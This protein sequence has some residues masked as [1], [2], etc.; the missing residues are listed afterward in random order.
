MRCMLCVEFCWI[1]PSKRNS[2]YSRQPLYKGVLAR[3]V[4][5]RTDTH[6]GGMQGMA[7]IVMRFVALDGL[8]AENRITMR[9]SLLL[10]NM[11]RCPKTFFTGT[12]ALYL[13][14]QFLKSLVASRRS[15]A[16]FN[17]AMRSVIFF[18]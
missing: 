1:V 7:R 6:Y 15:R 16:T 2:L 13:F 4:R 14:P 9:T 10:P 11:G 12:T 18:C 17:A 3:R 5:Q 8:G